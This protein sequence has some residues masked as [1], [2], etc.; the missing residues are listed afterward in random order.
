MKNDD[1]K[2]LAMNE[3]QAMIDADEHLVGASLLW[4]LLYS[5]GQKFRPIPLLHS[6]FPPQLGGFTSLL[7][8][9]QTAGEEPHFEL[10][11]QTKAR[12]VDRLE[13]ESRIPMMDHRGIR[14]IIQ[15]R[16][17]LEDRLKSEADRCPQTLRSELKE[18]K[19]YLRQYLVP[20]PRIRLFAST[21]GKAYRCMRQCCTRAL[22]ALERKDH[23]LASYVRAGFTSGKEFVW[24]RPGDPI[25]H[26]LLTQ[27]HKF[28]RP[29]VRRKPPQAS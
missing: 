1:Y 8:Q 26:S 13:H 6:V 29:L 7:K 27:R 22:D 19:R 5:E 12:A 16:N 18:I 9:C 2:Q 21:S 17:Y 4:F 23:S 11:A 10:L 15:R 3:L 25:T 28:R 24:N 20:G 14:E